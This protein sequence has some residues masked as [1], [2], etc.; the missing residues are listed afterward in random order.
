MNSWI[1]KLVISLAIVFLAL[2]LYGKFGPGIPVQSVVTQKQDLFTVSGEGKVTVV[3]DTGIIDVGISSNHSTVK[4]AQDQANTVI[5]NITSALRELD[6]DAK[7]IKTNNYSVYPQYDYNPGSV[8]GRITGYQ[9]NANLTV[10]VRELDKIN[11]VVD[12]ATTNGANTIGGIQLTVDESKQKELMQQ[13]RELA[14]N[15]AREKAESLARAAG[16]TLGKIVNV[17]EAGSPVY[18]GPFFSKD[19]A[20]RAEGAGGVPTDIQ[21]GSTDITTS[22]TLY[23][24]T[25]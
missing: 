3:P 2:V 12:S 1:G 25:R 8:P 15:E 13:A 6:I 22:V 23:Y 7:D 24:E 19:I 20:L 11:Q 16:I 5:N 17:V 9:V 18:P 4:A 21:P 10:T 14:V